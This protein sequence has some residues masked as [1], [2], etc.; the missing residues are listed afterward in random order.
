M[1]GFTV[2]RLLASVPVL[3]G[4]SLLVFVWLRA[5]PGSPAQ[6]LLG[7]FATPERVAQVNH[8]YGLDQPVYEQY[9]KFLQHAAQLDF[10]SSIVSGQPV[11]DEIAQRFPATAELAIAAMLF[12]IVFGIALG[13]V[14]ASRH[15]SIVDHA[16]LAISLLGVSV[17][18]F[19]LGLLL[20]YL[21]AVKLG[22][23]PTVGRIDVLIPAKHPTHFYVID[24]VITGNGGA[25]VSALEH[26]ILPA[27]SLG[28]IPLAIIARITRASVLDVQRENYVRTATAKGLPRK[29]INSRHILRNALLPVVTVIGVLVGLSLAGSVLTETVFAWP[30]M[31]SWLV[32]AISARDYPVLQGGIL[33]VALVFVTVNLVVDLSYGVLDPRVRYR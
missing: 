1:L 33:F 4:L 3:L 13:F 19:F 27:V 20:K 15:R 6:A 17:P 24:A 14:G 23:L 8:A 5:L 30:G 11:L 31:G 28:S 18:V 12:G 7:E 2:R 26:L 29:I 25:L 21:F 9:W 22:L 32:G 10:G 16:S